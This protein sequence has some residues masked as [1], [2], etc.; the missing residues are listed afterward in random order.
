MYKQRKKL[1]KKKEDK[2]NPP[3]KIKV[4]LTRRSQIYFEHYLRKFR[5]ELKNI[6]VN[7]Y[8]IKNQWLEQRQL[9]QPNEL[10]IYADD[11]DFITEDE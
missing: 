9:N 1:T 8:V 11:Y 7:I 2:T 4:S 3:I 5:E 6:P 10:I